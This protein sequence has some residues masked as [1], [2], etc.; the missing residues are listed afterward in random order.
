MTLAGSKAAGYTYTA[1]VPDGV[2]A[3]PFK[4]QKTGSWTYKDESKLTADAT[5]V[6]VIRTEDKLPMDVAITSATSVVL[7]FTF[8]DD[9][10]RDGKHDGRTQAVSGTWEFTFTKK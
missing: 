2:D 1:V 6:S 8:T 10:P 7:S 5:S 9:D 4:L 3:G